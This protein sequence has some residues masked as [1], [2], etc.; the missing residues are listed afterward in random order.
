MK[1]LI[2]G[3]LGFLGCHLANKLAD[4]NNEVIVVDNIT[5]SINDYYAS[6]LIEK[7][8]V[9]IIKIDLLQETLEEEIIDKLD[10]AIHLAAILGVNNV[11]NNPQ[12]TLDLNYRLL[13]QVLNAV[14]TEEGVRFIFASTSEVYAESVEK[15]ITIIP[16]PESSRIMLPELKNP[17][18]SYMLS[19][20][21]G[22]CLTLNSNVKP[23]I[24]RPHNLY[25]PRMGMKHV[26]PQLIN[27]M[28]K[29]N[30]NSELEVYSPEHTRTFC[31]IEDAV[32]QI[33]ALVTIQDNGE[34]VFN[35]G[36]QEPEI[37]MIDLAKMIA[38]IMDR[39]DILLTKGTNTQGSPYRR[40]PDTKRIDTL[41]GSSYRVPLE[42]GLKSTLDYYLNS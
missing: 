27:R 25:G 22:E 6:K 34:S 36:T 19:K 42:T 13:H 4:D 2:T 3:G 41:M 32:D 30:K 17:R 37:K 31:Y 8:N 15:G 9:K 1:I 20:L 14:K 39:E 28:I 38:K 26:I 7:E 33:R 40:C 12:Q 18:T 24:I 29:T 16:T 5:P 35:I 11:L 23:I 10:C 21:Y